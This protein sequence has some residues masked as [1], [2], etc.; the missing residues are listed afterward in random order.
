MR[1]SIMGLALAVARPLAARD[2]PVPADKGWQHAQTGLV[3]TA[4]I[5]GMRRTALTDATASEHDVMA[6]YQAADGSVS[7]TIYLFHPAADDVALWFDRS[8]TTLEQRDLFR[9]AA[10]ASADPVAFAAPG[11]S[12]PSALRQVYGIAGG[13]IRSTAL[14]AIPVGDWIVVIRM[15]APTLTATQ[16]DARLQ[17]VIG[18]IRW[19]KPAGMPAPAAVPIVACTTAL[20]FAKAQP[21][22]TP[23]ILSMLSGSI[24]ASAAK[25]EPA[26]PRPV[27][28]RDGEPRVEYGV[29]R[30]DERSYVMALYDA[31]RT[32]SVFPSIMGQIEKSG[33]YAVS[34]T[35]VDGTTS[36][37]PT[38]DHMPS[39]KQVWSLVGSGKRVAVSTGNRV[40]IDANAVK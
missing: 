38:F 22:K 29:Y 3:L 4:Q 36:A 12:T 32:V 6:Q 26:G 8:R 23:D 28:C 19:P 40:T 13:A 34:L 7:A 37:F 31:G 15:T 9:N 27:W 35:D 20:H 33:S 14:A 11:A 18:G 5:D 10:P 30:T 1:W 24:A 39:P 25:S 17:A 16:L 21:I 2:L